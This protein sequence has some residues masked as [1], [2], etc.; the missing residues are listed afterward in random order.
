MHETT[1]A[2][3]HTAQSS[4]LATS[5][6]LNFPPRTFTILVGFPSLLRNIQNIQN[7]TSKPTNPFMQFAPMAKRRNGYLGCRLEVLLRDGGVLLEDSPELISSDGLLLDQNVDH[8]VN[9]LPVVPANMQT[10]QCQQLIFGPSS[11][12]FLGV[13]EAATLCT[14]PLFMVPP[15]FSAA[16]WVHS[17]RTQAHTYIAPQLWVTQWIK[18]WHNGITSSLITALKQGAG[19]T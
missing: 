10:T 3:A 6:F 13:G 19:T 5:S 16:S 9:C 15:T 7:F 4:R 1:A 2:R 8:A 14:N 17:P 18:E 12:T 11:D